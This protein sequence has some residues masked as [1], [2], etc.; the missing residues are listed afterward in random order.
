M[1]LRLLAAEVLGIAGAVHGRL[2]DTD[3]GPWGAGASAR[4]DVNDGRAVVAPAADMRATLELAEGALEA[5]RADLE[6]VD[7]RVRVKGSPATGVDIAVLASTAAGDKLLLGAARAPRRRLPPATP[8]G[9]P[10]GWG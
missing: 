1:A 3:A 9:A 7:G 5:A 4:D 2:P 8:W 10:A 6:L